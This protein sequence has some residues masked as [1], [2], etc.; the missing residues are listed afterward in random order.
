MHASSKFRLATAALVAV[1]AFSMLGGTAYAKGKPVT[2][3]LSCTNAVGS[4]SATVQLQSTIFGPAASNP[5]TLDCGTASVSGL[6]TNTQTLKATSLPA[7]YVNYSISESSP[8]AGGCAG[9]PF[10]R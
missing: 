10:G 3:T 8:A 5:L 1:S 6:P 4:A 2:V 9:A 7:G